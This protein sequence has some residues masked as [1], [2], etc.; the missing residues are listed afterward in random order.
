MLCPKL[1]ILGLIL[2]DFGVHFS[3]PPTTYLLLMK[4][5]KNQNEVCDSLGPA[6]MAAVDIFFSSHSF[7]S[8]QPKTK[9]T[10]CSA[11]TI[12]TFFFV[13]AVLRD[14]RIG[15]CLTAIRCQLL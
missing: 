12:R 11:R 8:Y 13:V 15:G 7:N 3:R 1:H 9:W 14:D 5:K 4:D 2:P 10:Y 6:T